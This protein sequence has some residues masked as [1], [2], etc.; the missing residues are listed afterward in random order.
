MP[1]S[2]WKA[3]GGGPKRGIELSKH[4]RAAGSSALSP[5]QLAA[6]EEVVNDAAAAATSPEGVEDAEAQQVAMKNW[7]HG[8]R[9]KEG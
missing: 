1:V 3:A 4:V 7:V 6:L 2:G 9:E 8:E 5:Q